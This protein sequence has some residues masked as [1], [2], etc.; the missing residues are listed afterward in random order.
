MQYRYLDEN[1]ANAQTYLDGE[2]L[3]KQYFKVLYQKAGG[4]ASIC[5]NVFETI[6]EAKDYI[7]DRFGDSDGDVLVEI[8]DETG[9]CVHSSYL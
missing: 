4:R 7:D 8:L 2:V 6:E 9:K 3:T 5:K 1:S